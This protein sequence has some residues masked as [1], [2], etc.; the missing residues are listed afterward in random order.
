MRTKHKEPSTKFNLRGR[1][2][3]DRYLHF[4]TDD[5]AAVVDAEIEPIDLRR[6]AVVN[7]LFAA[8]RTAAVHLID[9]EC[10]RLAL[11]LA[12]QVAFENERIAVPSPRWELAPSQST[13][14]CLS[15]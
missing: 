7:K 8:R 1:L 15:G 6:G 12:R 3:V 5:S 14:N 2:H 13:T 4:A 9:C 11:S 10:D